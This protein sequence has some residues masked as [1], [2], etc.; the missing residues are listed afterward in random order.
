MM[1]SLTLHRRQ[2]SSLTC[3]NIRVSTR[4]PRFDGVLAHVRGAK[5]EEHSHENCIARVSVKGVSIRGDGVDCSAN[6]RIRQERP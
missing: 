2:T 4:S 5:R 1:K 3:L 6:L